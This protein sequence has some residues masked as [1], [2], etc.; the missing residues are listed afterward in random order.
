MSK[1]KIDV[2]TLF[3]RYGII[4]VMIGLMVLFSILSPVFFT[5][6]NLITVCRQ[7]SMIGI[8][9]VGGMFVMLIGG[10]DLTQGALVS[11]V[12]ILAAYLMT[13]AGMNMWVVI[14]IC[15][16]AGALVGYING[17]LVSILNIPALIATL[18]TQ[19]IFYGVAYLICG[20]QTISGF[21][22]A[23][24]VFGQG[25]VGPIPVPVIF[26]VAFFV[27]GGFILKKTYF[28]RSFY[29]LGGN[30]EA[31]KLSGINVERTKRMVYMLSGLFAGI[32]GIIML[33]RVNSGQ[34]NTG[35]GFEF[36]VI[37]AIVLGGISV[38]GGAGRLYNAIVGVLII[39][40]LNNGLVLINM[41]EYW[42]MIIKGVILAIAVGIDCVQK[43]NKG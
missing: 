41:S 36:D 32:A 28:G 15:V 1:S 6:N 5:F 13:K 8:A 14:I 16:I 34:A 10:I 30:A 4:L 2:K 3:S 42:Q 18:A 20:G 33:S 43:K 22:K 35:N 24:K 12:N 21:T 19:N 11:F 9:S 38:A 25:Y 23:F 27:L 40:M 17:L 39:G 29:A 31:A 7:V 26:M 37:T